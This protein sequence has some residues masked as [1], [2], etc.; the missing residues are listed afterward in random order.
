MFLCKLYFSDCVDDADSDDVR[1]QGKIEALDCVV[2]RIIDK[3]TGP[4]PA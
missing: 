4:K 1:Y 3:E 2:C